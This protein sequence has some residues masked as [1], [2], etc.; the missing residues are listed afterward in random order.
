MKVYIGILGDPA[1]IELYDERFYTLIQ[2]DETQ[3]L[4]Y[5]LGA[6]ERDVKKSDYQLMY[7][8]LDTYLHSENDFI[9][10]FNQSVRGQNSRVGLFPSSAAHLID[11]PGFLL[12]PFPYNSRSDYLR[13]KSQFLR[14]ILTPFVK[15]SVIPLAYF[16][17]GG[18]AAER[19]KAKLYPEINELAKLFYKARI[20]NKFSWYY[21]EAGSGEQKLS[22]TDIEKILLAQYN[23]LNG[24]AFGSPTTGSEIK[25]IPNSIYGGGITTVEMVEEILYPNTESKLI[26]NC[27]VIGNISENNI[28]MTSSII[29]SVN[30]FNKLHS[31]QTF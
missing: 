26:P 10:P 24:I 11:G 30:K 9:N 3:S 17:L 29:K 19:T 14:K 12:A 4:F 13:F 25:I 23:A 28:E 18:K 27:M 7:D 5:L 22:S 6:S 15:M 1:K 2:K 31:K 8:K 16:P 20:E 21:L